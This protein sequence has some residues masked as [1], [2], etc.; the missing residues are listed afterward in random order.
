MDIITAT[1]LKTYLGVTDATF[2]TLFAMYISAVSAAVNKYLGRE[3]VS[4]SYSWALDGSGTGLLWLPAWPIT[5]LTSVKE[6]GSTLTE[7]ED[8]DFRS[9]AD[10]GYL[11]KAESA[12]WPISSIWAKG[13]KNIDVVAV[14]GYDQDHTISAFAN[15]GTTVAGTVKATSAAHGFA[16]GTTAGVVISGTTNYNGTYTVTYISATEFY[17]TA[18][19]VATEVGHWVYPT[20]PADISL[21][22]YRKCAKLWK[23]KTSKN[24]GQSSRNIA[25]G[26]VSFIEPVLFDKEEREILDFHRRFTL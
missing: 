21:V 11:K 8:G 22:A 14:A 5:T 10:R 4:A 17:F 18:T 26:S 12:A 13:F 3:L 2:D 19:W 25:G 23:E 16:A 9:F 6:D 1:N 24:V 15:Y 20:M 7:G